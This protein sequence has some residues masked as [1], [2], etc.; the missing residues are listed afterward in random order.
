MVPSVPATTV[1][2]D[3]IPHFVAHADRTIRVLDGDDAAWASVDRDAVMSALVE[4]H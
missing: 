3:L 2:Q 1:V 4:E